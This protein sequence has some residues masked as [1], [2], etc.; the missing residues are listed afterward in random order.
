MIQAVWEILLELAPWLLSGTAIAGGLHALMPVGFMQRQLTGRWN[1]L[2]A[3]AIGVPLPLCS[4]SVIPVGLSLKRQGATNGAAIAFLISTP[5]TG[6]DSIMVSGAMLG[7]PFALFKMLSALVIGLTGGL[8][9]DW[10][11][12]EAAAASS[13]GIA[14]T[15]CGVHH[16]SR[17][18]AFFEHSR[19]L[20][21]SIWGWLVAGIVVSALINYFLPPGG[22][23]R[24][25]AGGGL[26]AMILTVLIG[27]PLYVCATASVP[28]AA[29][30]V[31]GGLP[32]GAALVFLIAGPAS[33]V[34]TM[35]AIYRGLGRRAFAIY[36][37][38]IAIGSIL[39]GWLFQYVLDLGG[40]VHL[41]HMQH[42]EHSMNS[43]W[44]VASAIVLLAILG[45]FAVEDLRAFL[46]RRKSNDVQPVL[47]SIEHVREHAIA[48]SSLEV[49][50]DGMTCQNCANCLEK[51]LSREE[52]V[53]DVAVTLNPDRAVVR[54]NI[55]AA[56][57]RE[58]IQ[59]A[60]FR[61]V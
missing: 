24:L 17:W 44:A 42:E 36:V 38:T 6:V 58:L 60:G 14:S 15:T 22:L 56:R 57:L 9:T 61:P 10:L 35:G 55:T 25:G 26:W 7:I 12:P 33:N 2:K 30:L 34:A 29:A 59:N 16:A 20:L 8:L 51:T 40:L 41:G 32:L 11:M 45:S 39:C 52:G 37:L 43:W 50:V 27:M 13:N 46:R 48:A 54:G 5:Q 21:E 3:A 19:M 31:H 53:A 47:Y 49:G 4:C 23:A 28:I 18:R 1:V